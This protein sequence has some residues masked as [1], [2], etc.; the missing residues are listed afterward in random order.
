M[1]IDPEHPGV[2]DIIDQIAV[3]LRS[4]MTYAGARSISEF[5]KKA[6]IGVQSNAGFVEGKAL[7]SSWS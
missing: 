6:I 4:S 1:Y 3:G 2:E 7:D 5:H